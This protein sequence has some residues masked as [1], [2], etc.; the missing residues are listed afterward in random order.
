M[1]IFS[2]NYRRHSC[3]CE[4]TFECK[5]CWYFII[6]NQINSALNSFIYYLLQDHSTCFGCSLHPSSGVNKTVVTTAGTSHVS[7]RWGLKSVKVCQGERDMAKRYN[8]EPYEI[9]NEPNII[10][11]IKVKR[12][13]WVEHLVRMNSDR[14][15][16][17]FTAIVDLSRF[18]NSCLKS[19]ASILVDLTFQLR[20]LRYFS[21]NQLR[22]LSL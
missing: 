15:L 9:F 14:T 10:N 8:Y 5:S 20:A 2:L 17:T 16:N 4:C 12:L 22:N 1:S 21:L 19:P 3:T 7:G 6:N 18:N 11:C 13:A